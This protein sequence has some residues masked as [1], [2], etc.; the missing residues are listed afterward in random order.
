[1]A[2]VNI[3]E[4]DGGEATAL[5]DTD[6]FEI[7]TG[8][9][10]KYILTSS[11]A[12]EIRKR[13]AS[14]A[15]EGLRLTWNSATSVSVGT[16]SC[17]TAGGDFINVTSA[18]TASSLSLSN[19]TWYH[20]YLYLSSGSPAL[21]VVTTAPAT[22]K[23]MAYSKT[24]DTS[25]RYVGSIR[26]DGSGNVL[27]FQHDPVSNYCALM[28]AVP[29]ILSNGKATSYTAVSATS[30]V[31]VTARF[32]ML[33]IVNSDASLNATLNTSDTSADVLTSFAATRQVLMFPCNSSQELRYK[34]SSTPTNGLFV[35]LLGFSFER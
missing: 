28:Y 19:S 30:Y 11:L 18:L 29:T 10:S 27:Q 6:G 26:T 2:N 33:V 34:Y 16:G 31:P 15:I 4:V 1:M 24:G 25:R 14:V 13:L 32:L 5:A 8:A 12:Y 17:Y 9:E 21:E 7:D 22:W 35:T 3:K 23:G 20:L